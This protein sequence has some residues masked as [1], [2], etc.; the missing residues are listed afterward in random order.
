MKLWLDPGLAA[1]S[2]AVLTGCKFLKIFLQVQIH[3]KGTCVRDSSPAHHDRV[4]G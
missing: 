2:C 4:E 3:P 1:I